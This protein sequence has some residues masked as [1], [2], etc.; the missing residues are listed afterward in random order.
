[1]IRYRCK[2]CQSK[3]TKVESR[4]GSFRQCYCLACDKR[5]LVFDSELKGKKD[6]KGTN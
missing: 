2:H 1:M 4:H 5:F 6:G 3:K